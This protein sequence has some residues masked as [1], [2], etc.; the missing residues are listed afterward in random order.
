MTTTYEA[1]GRIGAIAALEVFAEL[2]AEC[3]AELSVAADLKAFSVNDIVRLLEK[4][5]DAVAE[6]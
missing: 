5:R 1:V 3:S 6:L 4:A 2:L